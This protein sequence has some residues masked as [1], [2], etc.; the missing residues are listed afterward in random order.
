MGEVFKARH[1]ETGQAAAVKVL[2]RPEF[3]ARFRNE[4]EV[5]A[6]VSHPHLT[7]LYATD[8]LD[9]RPALVMEWVEGQS[10]DGLIRRRGRLGSEEAGRIGGQ[11]A[12]AVAHL[13]GKGIIHRDLKPSNVRIRPDG[14]VMV[15]DFGI[16]KAPHSPRLTQEGHA[17]GTSEFM[18]PEQFRS[19]VEAKSDVWALGVL[20]YEMTTGYLPFEERNPFLLR[21]QIERGQYTD[22]RL[23]N[24]ALSQR[25]GHLI[26][27]CL[28]TAPARRPSAAE[29]AQRLTKPA[30]TG[31]R[32]R[33]IRDLTIR[34]P[35]RHQV[36]IG[37]ALV[38]GVAL[39]AGI[40]SPLKKKE[41]AVFSRTSG[42]ETIRVEVVNAD[43]IVLILPNGSVQT[44]EPFLVEREAGQ[45]VPITIRRGATEQQF[46]IDPS[47]RALYQCYFD[48]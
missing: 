11:I 32:A 28:Q 38:L 41:E 23:L 17:V 44:R 9:D 42:R 14:S 20:L 7:A 31:Q 5:Q 45:A 47:V 48:R 10:L 46:V 18:A 26:G 6:S 19:R 30:Q 13:H 40:F 2:Y 34:T 4:A 25:L 37:L 3:E 8:L 21:A 16:A 1:L 24:P 29:L 35:F 22:P 39:V 43:N 27:R 12:V 15:L 33:F 36:L